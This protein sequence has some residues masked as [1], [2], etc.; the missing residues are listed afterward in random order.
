MFFGFCPAYLEYC[1][2]VWCLAADT[3]LNCWYIAY[4]SWVAVLRMLYNVRCNPM[5]HS[6]DALP[7]LHIGMLIW[8]L[9]AE[10]FSPSG[11]LFPSQCPCGTILPTLYSMVWD[12]WVSRVL[13]TNLLF[14]LSCSILTIVFYREPSIFTSS[15]R[16]TSIKMVELFV[17]TARLALGRTSVITVKIGAH[18]RYKIV[19]ESVQN[20]LAC[21]YIAPPGINVIWVSAENILAC[22]YIA[23]RVWKTYERVYR[24]FLHVNTS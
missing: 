8:L 7:E 18:N 21:K 2:A 12:W 5:H 24:I 4:C 16:T 22:K 9:A 19:W 1:S 14:G 10:S 3:Y 20:V 6:F 13:E 23:P 11:H 17:T 15:I